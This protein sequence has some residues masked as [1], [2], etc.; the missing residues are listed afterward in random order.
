MLDQLLRIKKDDAT[1]SF[2]GGKFLEE[3]INFISHKMKLSG[4]STFRPFIIKW[5]LIFG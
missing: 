3:T 5:L 2:N 4:G 1:Q